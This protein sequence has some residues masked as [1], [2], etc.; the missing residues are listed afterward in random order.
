MEITTGKNKRAQ[1]IVIY[2]PEGIGKSTFASQFPRA[3]FSDVEGSTDELDVARLPKPSSWEMLL[4]Q[5]L[6]LKNN[7]SKCRT[8]IIDTADWA[9]K[10]CSEHV[11]Y[12]SKK[13]G[14]ESFGYGKGYVYL[15]EEFGRFLNS[16]SDL[17]GVGI[18]VVFT[19]HAQM[20]K[21]EQPDE[22]GAYDRWEL[23]LQKKTAPLLKEWAD[24]LLFANYKTHVINVDDQGVQKGRNKVQGGK[25]IMYTTHHPCWDAKNR[26][27]LKEELPFDYKEIAHCI[28]GTEPQTFETTQ[29]TEPVPETVSGPMPEPMPET[30]PIQETPASTNGIPKEL[31]DLMRSNG[32]T[33]KDIQKA[34]A[35]KGYY[36]GDTPIS[37]YDPEFIKGVLIG[38]WSQVHQI[39]KELDDLPF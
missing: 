32:I 15:E 2:G 39:I 36:P 30:V 26:H 22:M 4:Q 35:H 8:W 1:K 5:A 19:A 6:Y 13:D 33:E 31:A 28:P 29:K 23:K 37:N 21:F 12:K 25:R 38:A 24:I 10:L 14:I 9:E 11:C 17:L 16:C 20:R 7:P 27:D 3:L 34:V 18:N